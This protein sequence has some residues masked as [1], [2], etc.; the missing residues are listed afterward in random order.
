RFSAAMDSW[1]IHC[2]SRWIDSSWH[3]EISARIGCRSSSADQALGA[4][5]KANVPAAVPFR[6]VRRLRGVMRVIVRRVSRSARGKLTSLFWVGGEAL[7][8][9]RLVQN[10][11]G[12]ET[13]GS[14][15]LWLAH[16]NWRNRDF[17]HCTNFAYE[18]FPHSEPRVGNPW[19]HR[20]RVAS[21]RTSFWVRP[22]GDALRGCGAGSRLDHLHC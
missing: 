20:R 12:C 5:A 3:F 8:H 19:N 1:W 15:R 22:F 2:W 10:K 17:V 11:N 4:Y 7:R 13:Q 18:D 9:S 14:L 21:A 16:H 6:K